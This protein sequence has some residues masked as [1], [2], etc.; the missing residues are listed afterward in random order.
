MIICYRWISFVSYGPIVE[1]LV[2][3]IL[4]EMVVSGVEVGLL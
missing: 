1:K 4:A 2:G 3:V